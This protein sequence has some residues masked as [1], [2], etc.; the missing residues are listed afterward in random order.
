MTAM[1][2]S[3]VLMMILTN[4]FVNHISFFFLSA[5]CSIDWWNCCEY[6]IGG[7]DLYVEGTFTWTSDN[8]TMGYVNWHPPSEP[9]NNGN[10]DCV[11][12]CRDEY[13]ADQNCYYV[14]PYICKAPTL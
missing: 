12:V 14:W 3:M 5:F 13:W 1:K 10:Q 11:S 2:K 4:L 6:W 7:S 9:D 8:S